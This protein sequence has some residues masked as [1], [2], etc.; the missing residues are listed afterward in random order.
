MLTTRPIV[1]STFLLTPTDVT[2][3]SRSYLVILQQAEVKLWKVQIE[4]F[5]N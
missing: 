2:E 3:S 4:K 5:E 1:S